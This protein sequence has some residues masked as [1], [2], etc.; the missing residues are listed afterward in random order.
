MSRI[1]S[2]LLIEVG[3]NEAV[4]RSE[5]PSIPIT[6]AEIADDI[7]ECC[8]AG[9]SIVHFHARDP[10][11]GEQ[12]YGS[13]ELYRDVVCRVRQAGSSVLMYPT[14]PPF[15][16]DPRRCID[17]RFAHVFELADE[18]ELGM[19]LG[20]LDMGSLN[21]VFAKDGKLPSDAHE[22]P[23]DWSVYQNPVP[24]LWEVAKEYDRR[25]MVTSLA[26]FEPGHLR[27]A[28]AFL[29]AGLCRRPILKFF[30]SGGWLHGPLPNPAGLAVYTAM[31][32]DLCRKRSVQWSCA[33]SGI[34]SAAEIETLLRAAIE[35]GG[36]VRVGIGD[37]PSASAGK[38]NRTLVADVVAIAAEYDRK[39]A[40]PDEAVGLLS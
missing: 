31:L 6:P 12:R 21:L 2:Q 30:L 23:M 10:D 11:S 33:P 16:S 40:R 27:L 39:P 32:R 1:T 36:H 20:P 26:I 8:E 34:D 29:D 4:S 28:M 17:E 7:L 15:F 35:Q 3:L 24:V 9:A 38:T 5:H 13:T 19:K 22:M 37:N 25:D 18:Q 14:Y